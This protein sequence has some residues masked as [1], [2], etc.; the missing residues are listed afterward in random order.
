M[1]SQSIAFFPL[2]GPGVQFL[3]PICCYFPR[4]DCLRQDS[5]RS[6]GGRCAILKFCGLGPIFSRSI[7]WIRF[8]L[9]FFMYDC[10]GGNF[11]SFRSPSSR[12]LGFCALVPLDYIVFSPLQ[13][14]LRVRCDFALIAFK[15]SGGGA[16]SRLS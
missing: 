4:L 2:L 6:H 14:L 10:L 16:I 12:S 15:S 1:G 3:V 13:I 7:C 8:P 5:I 9:I 11:S